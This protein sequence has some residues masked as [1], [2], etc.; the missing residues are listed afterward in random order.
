MLAGGRGSRL[1]GI[2]KGEIR[3]GDRRLIDVV[4]DAALA[5][6]CERALI[7]GGIGSSRAVSIREDPPFGG[8]AAGL[9]AALPEVRSD[10]IML[11]AC[12]LPHAGLL[13]HLL[14]GSFRH[15]TA[16]LDGLVA[17][18]DSRIQWLAGIYR[19][20]SIEK[21]V[22]RQMDLNGASLRSLLG[23]LKLRE[24]QDPE[25]LAHDIDTPEDLKALTRRE[26]EQ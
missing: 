10:W 7:A 24:V 8:P 26:E 1:G 22:A 5:A 18:S 15:I 14:A 3:L 25:R 17:L 21:A 2:E 20:S 23:D 4:V 6:G 13:C 9:A 16:E 12:D 11:L 19:R